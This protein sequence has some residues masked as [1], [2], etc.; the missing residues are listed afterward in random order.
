[1]DEIR[2]TNNEHRETARKMLG[3]IAS[4]LR[5]ASQM[6]AEIGEKKIAP[7]AAPEKVVEEVEEKPEVKAVP[8]ISNREKIL[9]VVGRY[10]EGIKLV[11]IG[12]ELGVNWRGLIVDVK[13][14]VDEDTVEKIDN[15]YYPKKE[16]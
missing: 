13:F 1:M 7:E 3:E 10:P 11:D 8:P 14:L 6:W 4:D 15:M 12:N 2:K 9:G 5:Q 16:E